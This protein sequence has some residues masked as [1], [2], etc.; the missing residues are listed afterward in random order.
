M[1]R[2]SR[3]VARENLSRWRDSHEMRWHTLKILKGSMHVIVW[4][5]GLV[6]LQDWECGVE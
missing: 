4:C 1:H 2:L 6:G 5:G 3:L